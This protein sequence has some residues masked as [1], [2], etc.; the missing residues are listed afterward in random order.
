MIIPSNEKTDISFLK[1]W[2]P[3]WFVAIV[4]NLSLQWVDINFSSSK[5]VIQSIM[6]L[7][8][9]VL[10]ENNII[11]VKKGSIYFSNLSLWDLLQTSNVTKTMCFP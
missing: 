1:N 3:C 11:S 10:P 6:P 2:F 4:Q 5:V 7:I 8:S 9:L